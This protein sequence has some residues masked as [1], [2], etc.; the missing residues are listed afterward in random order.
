MSEEAG[1]IRMHG[2][3]VSSG[4]GYAPALLYC[5]KLL[6]IPTG[7]CENVQEEQRTFYVAC[8]RVKEQL[9]RSREKAAAAADE[10]T[11]EIFEA[12]IEILEDEDTVAVPVCEQIASDKCSAAQAVDKQFHALEALMRGAPDPYIQQRADDFA[13]LREQLLRVLL[14]CPKPDISSLCEDVILV[15]QQLT[16]S[17]TMH[18]D[19]A[20]IAGI[21]CVGGSKTSHSAILARSMRIPAIV[22]CAEAME[23]VKG[24]E[25][26]LIDGSSGEAVLLPAEK[27]LAEFADIRAALTTQMQELEVYRDQE[28]CTEDGATIKVAANVASSAEVKHAIESGADG[29]G[30]FRSEFLYMDRMKLPSEEEQF[31]AY[32]DALEAAQGRPV[33]I[34]TLD[35][36]G[37]KSA[38]AIQIPSEENPF[39]GYRAIRICLN[40]TE[41]FKTQLRALYRASIYGNLLIM[42]PMISSLEELRAAKNLATQA[43]EELTREG[44]AFD[45]Q[46]PLGM[47][48]EVPAAAMLADVFAQEADFFSIGTNDLIQYTVAVDRGNKQIENLYD[49]HHP[50]VLR[51]IANTISAA[52]DAGIPC[53]MC[54]EAAGEEDFTQVLLGY[55]LSQFSVSAGTVAGLK[56]RIC[57]SSC[58]KAK[59]LCVQLSRLKTAEEITNRLRQGGQDK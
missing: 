36:G 23:T 50:A 54:G 53:C 24:G 11:A 57:H 25:P 5:P 2:L 44:I 30:L 33:T 28:A 42:F 37:D 47:M 56:K 21:L 52:A 35:I 34:R 1:E 17:D 32:R 26:L 55:G 48:I 7:R 19:L 4:I 8:R 9:L 49:Y 13:D 51:L 45:S 3:G 46:V 59:A 29:I 22:G 41:L 10:K 38:A 14:N 43:R 6:P 16:P 18:V 39:L 58:E 12:H 40:D 20:H 27:T 31:A 15:A